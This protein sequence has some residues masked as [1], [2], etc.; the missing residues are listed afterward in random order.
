M[1]VVEDSPPL[2]K[3][4]FFVALRSKLE[5]VEV[6]NSAEARILPDDLRID[7][8]IV[9]VRY[10]EE[11]YALIEQLRARAIPVI[12]NTEGLYPEQHRR[13][14]AAGANR[15]FSIPVQA[16]QLIDLVNELLS[17]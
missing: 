17:R 8:A 9:S 1:L 11:A 12:A 3:L 14:L 2:Q 13:A 6:L 10:D 16:Q 15:C 7:V 4:F 5:L